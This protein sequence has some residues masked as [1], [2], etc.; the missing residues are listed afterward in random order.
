[1]TQVQALVGSSYDW[2]LKATRGDIATYAEEILAD[3][4]FACEKVGN[5]QPVVT[6]TDIVQATQ[7]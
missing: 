6:R 3:D 5:S 1:M 2:Q 4:N 7:G